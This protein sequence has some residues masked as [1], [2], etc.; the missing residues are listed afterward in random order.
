M[1]KINFLFF[2][3]KV[4]FYLSNSLYIYIIQSYNNKFHNKI[5]DII[6]FHIIYRQITYIMYLCVD[7]ANMSD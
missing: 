4:D 1:V 2:Y 6:N 5:H 7:D 3:Y